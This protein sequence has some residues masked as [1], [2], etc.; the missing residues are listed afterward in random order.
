MLFT[1]LIKFI[2]NAGYIFRFN[3]KRFHCGN[4]RFTSVINTRNSIPHMLVQDGR[5]SQFFGIFQI[6]T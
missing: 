4:D 5:V 2:N 6:V 3:A 1:H